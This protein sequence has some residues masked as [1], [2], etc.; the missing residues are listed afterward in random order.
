MTTKRT[1]SARKPKPDQPLLDAPI[2][3]VAAHHSAARE[4]LS[5]E[6]LDRPDSQNVDLNAALSALLHGQSQLLQNDEKMRAE[7]TKIKARMTKMEKEQAKYDANQGKYVE[8]VFDRAEKMKLSGTKLDQLKARAGKQFTQLVQEAAAKKASDH[9]KFVDL[10]KRGKKRMIVSSG[11]LEMR[12]VR[13]QPTPTV[14]PEVVRIKDMTWTIPVGVE[15]EVPEI[16]ARVL[17][18]RRLSQA[19]TAERKALMSADKLPSQEQLIAGT[20]AINQKYKTATDAF[21]LA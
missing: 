16:V 13:G 15:T 20:R 1:A 8:D 9:L 10:I 2:Q 6:Y 5:P 14:V 3:E 17:D 11:R 7:L 4:L 21:P 12:S 18:Q 19:E